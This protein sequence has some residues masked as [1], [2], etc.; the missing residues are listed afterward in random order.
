VPGKTGVWVG[1]RKLGAVGVRISHGISSH[2]IALNVSTDLGAYRHIVPCGTPDKAMTS[3][4]AELRLQPCAGGGSGGRGGS[5][6]SRDER[7]GGT[8]P[9]MALAERCLVDGV[10]RALRL[11]PATA[12]AADVERLLAGVAANAAV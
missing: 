12:G 7:S 2:G 1:D 6:G 8:L 9:L 5:G 10:A 4:L 3:L 11:R